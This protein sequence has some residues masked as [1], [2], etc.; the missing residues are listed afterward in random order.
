MFNFAADEEEA[1][2]NTGAVAVRCF[3]IFLLRQRPVPPHPHHRREHDGGALSPLPPLQPPL[4]F[5]AGSRIHR[6][7][8]RRAIV[9]AASRR[10]ALRT[11][12]EPLQ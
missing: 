9:D 1:V 10:I 4:S 5:V 2:K 12:S 3:R 11:G 7:I 8:Q 6:R